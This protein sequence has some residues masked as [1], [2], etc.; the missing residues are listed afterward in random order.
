[1]RP[2]VLH[3][4]GMHV[5]KFGSMERY[6]LGIAEQARARGLQTMLQYEAAP[7]SPQY[8]QELAAAGVP[9]RVIPTE[10]A[11]PKSLGAV[12]RL[13]RELRPAVIHSHFAERHVILAAALAGRVVGVRRVIAMVHNV[14]HLTPRSKARLAYNRCDWVLGVSDAV[15][16][17]LRNGGVASQR[18]RTHYMGVLDPPVRDTQLRMALRAEFDIPADVPVLGNIAFDAGFKGVDVLLRALRILAD[19]ETPAMLLQI[20]VDPAQSS[21]R[22]LARGLG[23]A[24]RVRW[25]GIRD[26]GAAL[27][28]AADIYVQP[29]RF[30]EGLPLA[31]LEAMSIGLPVVA[32]GVAGNAEAVVNEST[33]FLV[34]AG[35]P[36]ALARGLERM[37]AARG[38]WDRM[39]RAG[40]ARARAVFDGTR[41]VSSLVARYYGTSCSEPERSR[42]PPSPDRW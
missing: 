35:D 27:L 29:S 42:Y 34:A 14:H 10:K 26:A 36:V 22:G 20:G 12:V 33:G 5:T 41:S 32:T 40:E 19:H 18:V 9:V 31:I 13:L 37:L 1:M 7:A 23:V 8:A 24:D 38:D 11:G 2:I 21:L 28:N 4:T 39:G 30:G 3:L 16:E 6:L 15:A 17:D 25:V